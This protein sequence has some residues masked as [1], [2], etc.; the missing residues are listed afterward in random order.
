MV[1]GKLDAFNSNFKVEVLHCR[2][3]VLRN[4]HKQISLPFVNRVCLKLYDVVSERNR[5]I[6]I[7]QL[8]ATAPPCEF[9][10]LTF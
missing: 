7:L 4:Y 6:F 8:A 9:G 3:H 2:M 5:K 1:T 10:H